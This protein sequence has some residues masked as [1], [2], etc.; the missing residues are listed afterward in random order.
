VPTALRVGAGG[1][2]LYIL[3]AECARLNQTSLHW[4]GCFGGLQP[5][6]GVGVSH[7]T[8]PPRLLTLKG[9]NLAPSGTGENEPDLQQFFWYEEEDV[10]RDL[11][12]E[13]GEEENRIDT[14][15]DVDIPTL[16]YYS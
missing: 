7:S 6:S 13:E 4:T 9:S 12:V 2:S 16:L 15:V 3:P 5:S 10:E 1:W 14:A 8:E 11:F